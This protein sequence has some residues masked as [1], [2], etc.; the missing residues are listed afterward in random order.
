MW[1]LAPWRSS[2][3]VTAF[4]YGDDASRTYDTSFCDEFGCYGSSNSGSIV[5]PAINTA[6]ASEALLTFNEWRQVENLSPYDRAAVL[7]S[8]DGVNWDTAWESY[9]STGGWVDRA[10]DLTSWSGGD[11]YIQFYFDTLDDLYN[12]FEGWYVD[13]VTIW[14]AGAQEAGLYISNTSVEE[15][16]GG[17]VT[18]HFTVS[19]ANTTTGPV[20]VDWTTADGTATVADG[21]YQPDSGTLSFGDGD[22]S[23]IITVSVNGDRIDEATEAFFVT[24]SNPSGAE[25]VVGQGRGTIT[26]NDTAGITIN[27]ASGLVTSE[28]G[29]SSSL[30][31]VLNSK[32]ASNVTVQL[33]SSDTTE[34]NVPATTFI[35]TPSNW[36]TPQSVAVTGVNDTLDDGDVGYTI[37]AVASSSDGNYDGQS[38]QVGASNL[39][40]DFSVIYASNVARSIPD[41]GAAVLSTMTLG[42]HMVLDINVQLRITHG[43]SEDLDVHLTAPDGTKVELFTDV[44][45]AGKNF[46]NTVL[47]DEASSAIT[48]GS[49]PFSGTYR[50]EGSLA[51]FD[52]KNS[53]GVWS[54]SVQD[55][56]KG[57]KGTL[58][59]W[60]M[61]VVYEQLST[62]LR[63]PTGGSGPGGRAGA[64]LALSAACQDSPIACDASLAAKVYVTPSDSTQPA[65]TYLVRP[66]LEQ[67]ASHL[68]ATQ[69]FSRTVDAVLAL[70]M[71]A[72]NLTIDDWSEAVIYLFS[73]TNPLDG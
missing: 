12:Y 69:D 39:D 5:S 58:N 27:P 9:A 51:A 20:T 41:G 23:Q 4:Y 59:Q 37:S 63:I 1:H 60:S 17:T 38:S 28:S 36:S 31:V 50:P 13:D 3:P 16:D 2:S 62:A 71:N 10:V 29:G 43:R 8:S 22:T 24:L 68:L 15:G 73:E 32:P 11:I 44:G 33:T 40:N 66:R 46:T 30:G 35:F 67:S 49:A 42:S 34:G 19:L 45:G 7:V 65:T 56:R 70:T 54:L 57:Q 55:D 25:I 21:D 26:D 18:A 14:V 48:S 61:T 47:D 6:G 72:A 52:A 64:R 53:Q